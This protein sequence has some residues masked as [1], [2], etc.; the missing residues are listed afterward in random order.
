MCMVT[1]EE[2]WMRKEFSEKF[3]WKPNLSARE[4]AEGLSK[5]F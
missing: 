1:A 5:L 3:G 2:E 4:I